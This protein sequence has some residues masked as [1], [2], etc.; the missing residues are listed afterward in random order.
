MVRS[1]ES[2]R[3][4]RVWVQL[5]S[6]IPGKVA[7]SS[8]PL[9]ENVMLAFSS[10]TPLPAYMPAQAA[11]AVVI[12][13]AVSVAMQNRATCQVPERSPPQGMKDPQASPELEPPEPV[14]PAELVAPPGELL[15]PPEPVEPAELVVPPV[16]SPDPADPPVPVAFELVPAPPQPAIQPQPSASTKRP[17]I[18][19]SP[20]CFMVR[21]STTRCVDPQSV[22]RMPDTVSG[23][24]PGMD[25][26]D[27][28]GSGHTGDREHQ[29]CDDVCPLC[30]HRGPEALR[31]AQLQCEGARHGAN[32]PR[33]PPH[34]E[35]GRHPIGLRTPVD[36]Q[37]RDRL[38]RLPE[39]EDGTAEPGPCVFP[40]LHVGSCRC[41]MDV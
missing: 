10:V 3:H 16:E 9:S 11:T 12:P 34:P 31:V 37:F 40:E 19:P 26:V 13:S 22:A 41:Q 36:P 38:V 17:V 15:D 32:N 39:I 28:P 5:D 7:R 1:P 27:H 14:E 23:R 20:G 21:T 24:C 25:V 29:G 6:V 4:S 8:I 2:D 18:P 33:S 30:S 35:P